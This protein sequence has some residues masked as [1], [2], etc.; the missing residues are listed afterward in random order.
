MINGGASLFVF[1]LIRVYRIQGFGDLGIFQIGDSPIRLSF[2]PL[3]P[4]SVASR[5]S[6]FSVCSRV[7]FP[8]LNALL[9][10]LVKQPFGCAGG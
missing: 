3:Y 1:R 2:F 4:S 7:V 10:G 9:P 8:G 6:I 5:A